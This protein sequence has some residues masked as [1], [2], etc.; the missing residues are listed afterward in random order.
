MA[1]GRIEAATQGMRAI[2]ETLR[3]FAVGQA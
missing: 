3:K 2:E 1:N